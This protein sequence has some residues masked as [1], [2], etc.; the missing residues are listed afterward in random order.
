MKGSPARAGL[1][2]GATAYALWGLFPAYLKLLPATPPEIVAHRILWSIPFGALILFAVKQWKETRAAFADFRTLRMLALSALLI[3]GNWLLYVW[4]V[5]NHRVIEASL[6]YYINPLVFIGFGVVF[7]GE[8]LSR[9]QIVAVLL[10]A[11]GVASLVVGAGVFPWVSLILAA[12]FSS[13][14][15]VRKTTPVGAMPGLFIETALLAPFAAAFA[16]FL[17]RSGESHFATGNLGGDA[18]LVLAGPATVIP[19]VLFALAARRLPLTV[20]GFLQYIGPTLQLML[21]LYYGEPFT[22]A[23]LIAFS[24]IWAAL[25]LVS[26]DAVLRSRK[27]GTVSASPNN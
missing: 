8:R 9:F 20:M 11:A 1:V 10:A 5:A 15:F 18:L 16:F 21:G 13:Y 24:L 14:G 26:V 23:H 6:G 2:C 27:A 3:S 7:L 19:L 12:S 4:A 17:V 22:R 25:A